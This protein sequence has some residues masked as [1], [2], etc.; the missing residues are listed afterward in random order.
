MDLVSFHHFKNLLGVVDN[1]LFRNE[2][3]IDIN[4]LSEA[5]DVRRRELSCWKA[6]LAQGVRRFE[7]DRALS[8]RASD[9]NWLEWILGVAESVR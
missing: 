7:G 2:R 6:K 9:V 5:A 3:A 4:A 1:L 8:I